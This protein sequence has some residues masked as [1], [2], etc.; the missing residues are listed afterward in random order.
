M[1]VGKGETTMVWSHQMTLTALPRSGDATDPLRIS[2]RGLLVEPCPNQ[3]SSTLKCLQNLDPFQ[4]HFHIPFC[5]F[6][7]AE[8]PIFNGRVMPTTSSVKTAA[9]GA[10]EGGSSSRNTTVTRKRMFQPDVRKSLHKVAVRY[11]SSLCEA[12]TANFSA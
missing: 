1:S 12:R 10:T 8:R 7:A 11:R 3:G 9:T 6:V 5:T 4:S 2:L